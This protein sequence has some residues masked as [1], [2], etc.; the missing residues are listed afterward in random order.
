ML[1]AVVALSEELVEQVSVGSRVSVAE[2]A[3][4]PVVPAGGFVG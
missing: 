3:P 4:L 1:Q 2:I